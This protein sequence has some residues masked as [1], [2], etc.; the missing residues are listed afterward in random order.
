MIGQSALVG[1]TLEGTPIGGSGSQLISM[2]LSWIAP[3][4]M[5]IF[6]VMAIT[7][8][9]KGQWAAAITTLGLGVVAGIVLF[10]G[11]DLF[12]AALGDP[13]ASTS[14]TPTATTPPVEEVVPARPPA[15]LTGLW[16]TLGIIGAILLLGL[17][18]TGLLIALKRARRDAL[19]LKARNDAAAA[20][21]A[22]ALAIWNRSVEKHD[23][24]SSKA[25]EIET[26][27]DILFSYPALLDPS[28]PSTREF[29][30]ALKAVDGL[31][32]DAPS[33]ISLTMDIPE[34]PYPRLVAQADSAWI[35][36]WSFAQRTG[37][38]LIPRAERKKLD[39]IVKL[40]KLARDGGGSEHERSV[41]YERAAKLIGELQFV[42]I[43]PRALQAI[44]TETRLMLEAGSV[45]PAATSDQ[46]A[47]VFVG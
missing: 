12:S 13:K 23:E 29:H 30:R 40:L 45:L 4:L 20:D 3:V 31:S 38:K 16:L 1:A 11:K 32:K 14:P 39:Q 6:V 9:F 35:A 34:L 42:H 41:A 28:I 27:W 36:A 17:L 15:D 8:V 26:D 33:D 5:L 24:L 47:R 37:T 19:E 10:F 46:P 18:A 44:G 7:F 43:P 25:Y 2:A 22:K 21:R